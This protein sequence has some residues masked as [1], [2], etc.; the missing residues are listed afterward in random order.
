M[1]DHTD[2]D[3]DRLRRFN[4]ILE[5]GRAAFGDEFMPRMNEAVTRMRGAVMQLRD[6]PTANSVMAGV[7][8]RQRD[9]GRR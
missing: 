1:L 3:L 6:D 5:T 8:T 2:Y 7:F 9:G 4:Q